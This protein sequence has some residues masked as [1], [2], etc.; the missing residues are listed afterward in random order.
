[1]LYNGKHNGLQSSLLA[2]VRPTNMQNYARAKGWERVPTVAGEIAVYHWPGS[3]VA[4][5]IVP[6]NPALNDYVY[7]IAEAVAALSEVEHRPEPEILNDLLIPP[8]DTLR[9]H[10]ASPAEEDGTL[11]FT[12]GINLLTSTRKA[13]MAS[14]CDVLNPKTFHPRLSRAEA[15]QF[16]NSCRLGQT[17]RG[18]FVARVICPLDTQGETPS[19]FPDLPTVEESLTRQVTRHLMKALR[20]IVQSIQTDSSENLTRFEG[21]QVVSANLYEALAEMQP[22]GD[23]SAL[24]VT[25]VWAPTV[26]APTDIPNQVTLYRDYFPVIGMAGRLLRPNKEPQQDHFFGVVDTL[27]GEPDEDGQMQ[28]AVTLTIFLPED[29]DVIRARLELS[30]QDYAT[31]CD[32]HKMAR[33]VEVTGVLHRAARLHTLQDYSNFHTWT[34]AASRENTA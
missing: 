17:E 34:P 26:P 12:D 30:P 27:S 29:E 9:F 23:R 8:A 21:E 10:V 18:S 15:E 22:P 7:R 25:V 20:R 31:A 14:A 1:M 33:P 11:P 19:L 3:N 24:Q 13:L 16:V 32:A 6:Q 4:E 5:L 2:L 28:G